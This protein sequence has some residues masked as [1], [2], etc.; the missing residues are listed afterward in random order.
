[1]E[2]YIN[3]PLKIDNW[4][5]SK[6]DYYNMQIIR[7]DKIKKQKQK[8]KKIYVALLALIHILLLT[9]GLLYF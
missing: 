1:M 7:K 9:I 3:N 2:K 4:D 5:P 8:K 6:G